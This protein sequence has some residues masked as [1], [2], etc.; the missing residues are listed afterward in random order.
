V[1]VL[2][3]QTG[4]HPKYVFS[5][6]GKPI[7]QVSTKA[8]YAAL[9]RAGIENFRQHDLRHTWTSWHV[10]AGTPLHVLQEFGAW[11]SAEMVRRHAH[12]S[13]VHLAE[14]VDRVP[15]PKLITNEGNV[16]EMAT[17]QLRAANKRSPYVT[18]EA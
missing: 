17:I 7:T 18:V 8:W 14:Y 12:L 1:V 9:E 3:E 6:R 4:K 5:F 2:R 13:T 10:Q 11:E 15:K 16:T